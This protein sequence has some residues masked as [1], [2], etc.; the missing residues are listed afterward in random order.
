MGA[1]AFLKNPIIITLSFG[2]LSEIVWYFIKKKTQPKKKAKSMKLDKK[3][4]YD[5]LFFSEQS[6]SCRIHATDS[7]PCSLPSCPIKNLNKLLA[8]L[9]SA[10]Q[11]LD[12][13]IYFF[14]YSA[15]VKLI[16]DLLMKRNVRI[17]VILDDESTEND[18]S[19]IY[20][21]RKAG[22]L[23]RTRKSPYLMHHK[24]AIIDKKL[25]IT[26]SA[27]WTHQAFFGN[28]ENILITNQPEIVRSYF[29]EYEKIWANYDIDYDTE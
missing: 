2:V 29:E 15:I 18:S 17:R 12:I 9:S 13:C 26:G 24:F 1:L 6:A 16:K 4:I 19:Q 3:R 8:Y 10:E 22:M 14:T 7:H 21:M 27:N 11:T 23:V 25:L 20:I 5:V 28:C